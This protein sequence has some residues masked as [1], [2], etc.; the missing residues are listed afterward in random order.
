[1]IVRVKSKFNKIKM[2]KKKEDTISRDRP[3]KILFF[4]IKDR[5]NTAPVI[6][7]TKINIDNKS[8]FNG[9]KKKNFTEINK[10]HIVNSND[11]NKN[12]FVGGELIIIEFIAKVEIRLTT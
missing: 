8:I 9:N 11:Q 10:I 6:H 5:D 1:M 4:T 3:R 12:L 2:I 7:A